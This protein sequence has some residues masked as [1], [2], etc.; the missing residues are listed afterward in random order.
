MS[1][2]Q[3]EEKETLPYFLVHEEE[4]QCGMVIRN[5]LPNYHQHLQFQSLNTFIQLH[6]VR[7]LIGED[8]RKGPENTYQGNKTPLRRKLSLRTRRQLQPLMSKS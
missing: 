1:L 5:V 7:I 4:E 6:D 2:L 3:Q 8:L